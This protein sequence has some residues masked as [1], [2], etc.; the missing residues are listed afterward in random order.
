MPG[1]PAT[2]GEQSTSNPSTAANQQP[3]DVKSSLV[4]ESPPSCQHQ[5]HAN[6][7][8]LVRGYGAPSGHRPPSIDLAG[9]SGGAVISLDKRPYSESD[10]EG[11]AQQC[12][13]PT[14][15]RRRESGNG[16][17]SAGA[18]ADSGFVFH[19]PPTLT[20]YPQTPSYQSPFAVEEG[21]WP[22]TPGTPSTPPP[23]TPT[24]PQQTHHFPPPPPSYPGHVLYSGHAH[25]PDH[26][27]LHPQEPIVYHPELGPGG[28]ISPV[29]PPGSA[30]AIFMP[31][32][33]TPT[34]SQTPHKPLNSVEPNNPA[35]DDALE[36]MASHANHTNMGSPLVL[37]SVDMSDH[38]P[39]HT[40]LTDAT[41][42]H[43]TTLTD[44]KP[45]PLI[46][47]G[48]N[49]DPLPKTNSKSA[50]RISP[51]ERR[52]AGSS[53]PMGAKRKSFVSDEERV[54]KE[55]ERRNANN[56][57]ERIRV[58]DINEAFKELGEICH[59]YLQVE[60][61]QT[62]LMILHQ[63]VA[64]ISSLESQVRDRHLNPKAAC[65]QKREEEKQNLRLTSSCPPTPT[66]PGPSSQPDMYT[67]PP[68][69]PPYSTLQQ[70]T[71]PH[72]SYTSSP[73]PQGAADKIPRKSD[74]PMKR[75]STSGSISPTLRKARGGRI[76][77]TGGNP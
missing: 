53:K 17:K 16:P 61:A 60:K 42:T 15:I 41:D 2:N 29:P 70:S 50:G 75:R 54:G 73:P 63:A 66:E 51:G 59:D 22:I 5:T 43:S 9:M 18:H 71:S 47:T 23:L 35:L 45:P 28:M 30:A 27:I 11:P 34:E 55:R 21:L 32:N 3:M 7:K 31:P 20:D 64:V 67:R 49:G 33:A 40:L 69:T 14:K 4:L 25:P 56:Q 76:L 72:T 62:K 37:P 65:L 57:R 19:P 74:P 68:P 1:P 46:R 12:G 26:M 44:H 13:S 48:S 39:S 77:S 10:G 58:R 24:F 8:K 38:I 36:M 52:K 6:S